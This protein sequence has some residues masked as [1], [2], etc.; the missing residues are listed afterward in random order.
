MPQFNSFCTFTTVRD[1]FLNI[2]LIQSGQPTTFFSGAINITVQDIANFSAE[3][4]QKMKYMFNMYQK[5]RIVKAEYEYIPSKWNWQTTSDNGDNSTD[6]DGATGQTAYLYGNYGEFLM[7]PDSNDGITR[8]NLEE[9]FQQKLN[10]NAV[11]GPFQT[12]KKLTVVPTIEDVI[13]ND[14]APN[15]TT[16]TQ[17]TNNGNASTTPNIF[18][19]T[20][21]STAVVRAMPWMDTHAWNG[22]VGNGTY[23]N[24]DQQ[25]FA[26]K[27]Y[28]YLPWN[29]GI[30]TPQA[31]LAN[32]GIIRR[33]CHFEFKDI[34]TRAP[35]TNI[36]FTTDEQ[37]AMVNL[38]KLKGER[39]LLVGLG[40][41]EFAT[42]VNRLKRIAE[43]D[44]EQSLKK[45][46]Q[47]Y[48]ERLAD[49]AKELNPSLS[50]APKPSSLQT[51]LP[52]QYRGP[53]GLGKKA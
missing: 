52:H 23:Y 43:E 21:W 50:E 48:Q 16:Q 14:Q 8:S 1:V 34:E 9:Y 7:T 32:V 22:V 4:F 51:P 6:Y 11:Q 33:Y 27:Y 2:P 49:V 47:T 20:D 45:K 41:T 24:F 25:A 5:Y 12:R 13:I 31:Q 26:M 44:Q 29:L 17:G 38:R 42:P 10:P 36:S 15:G 30:G 39:E 35:I 18:T 28:L 19:Q 40:S 53:V 37:T 3:Q 46:T